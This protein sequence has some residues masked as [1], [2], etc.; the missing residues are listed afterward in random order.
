LPKVGSAEGGHT[1]DL[2]LPG[3]VVAFHESSIV[4]FFPDWQAGAGSPPDVHDLQ[5]ATLTRSDP[6]QKIQD[7]V[8]DVL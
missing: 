3:H 7:Q 4:G 6:F 8:I 2:T 5:I 1:D